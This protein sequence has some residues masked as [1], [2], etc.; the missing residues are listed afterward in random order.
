MNSWRW[1]NCFISLCIFID[2]SQRLFPARINKWIMLWFRINV[3]NIRFQWYPL[4]Y[5]LK[6]IDMLRPV[7]GSPTQQVLIALSK[8]PTTLWDRF[9]L[10][11]RLMWIFEKRKQLLMTN[12]FGGFFFF[13]LSYIGMETFWC[14]WYAVLF[15][16]HLFC[17]V[18]EL[19]PTLLRPH[20]LLPARLLCPW[21]FPGKNIGVGRHFLLQGI[22]LTQGSNPTLQ[23]DSLPSEPPGKS[24]SST[25]TEII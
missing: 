1:R 6:E 11:L 18:T 24:F 22:L 2:I 9:C 13:Y 5:L 23:A 7:G 4:R 12:L 15:S 17:L 16:K 20:G 8:L 14:R 10:K 3:F 19:C 25:I 21:D